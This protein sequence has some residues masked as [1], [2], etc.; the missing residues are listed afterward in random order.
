MLSSPLALG[1]CRFF[2]RSCSASSDIVDTLENLFNSG[3]L[4]GLFSLLEQF[5]LIVVLL[6]DFRV[7]LTRRGKARCDSRDDGQHSG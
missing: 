3:G 7:K 4:K 5:I 6:P 2:G 1:Q